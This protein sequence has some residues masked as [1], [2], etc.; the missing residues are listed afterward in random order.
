MLTDFRIISRETVI[1]GSWSRNDPA[2]SPDHA[3]SAGRPT[4]GSQ[5][6]MTY[7]QQGNRK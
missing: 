3:S 7:K 6:G 5:P 1:D 2:T 4:A